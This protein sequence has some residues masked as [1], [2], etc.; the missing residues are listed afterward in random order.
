MKSAQAIVEYIFLSILAI[1]LAALVI[2]GFNLS[3][4]S[5]GAAFGIKTN[6]HV[7]T[8]PPMTP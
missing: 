1:F 3:N 2:W 7:I 8:I 4:I 6:K 5:A